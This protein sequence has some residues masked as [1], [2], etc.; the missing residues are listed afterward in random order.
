MDVVS[1]IDES[2]L[3]GTD[4][5]PTVI[6]ALIDRDCIEEAC[7]HGFDCPTHQVIVCSGCMEGE[8]DIG[9]VATATEWPC[10][11]VKGTS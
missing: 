10:E 3:F 7:E 6:D 5:H 11:H 8:P 1:D 4:H 2:R 9:M